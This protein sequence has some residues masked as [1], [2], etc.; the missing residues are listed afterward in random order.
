[1]PSCPR[2]SVT[3]VTRH[4]KASGYLPFAALYKEECAS[5]VCSVLSY[6]SQDCPH[7]PS[8]LLSSSIG[9][10][11]FQLRKHDQESYGKP[12]CHGPGFV[13]TSARC[14]VQSWKISVKSQKYCSGDRRKQER[15]EC[16][17]T[18][19]G[20]PMRF[21]AKVKDKKR[22]H[23]CLLGKRSFLQALIITSL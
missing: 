17:E 11:F 8:S 18:V 19:Q 9:N 16:Q 3:A 23:I 12:S 6:E 4:K 15:M 7:N 21:F 20:A 13:K 1:M 10:T 22:Q 2:C 14:D 5:D